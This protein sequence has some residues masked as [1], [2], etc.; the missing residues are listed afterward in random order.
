MFIRTT[1]GEQAHHQCKEVIADI[2]PAIFIFYYLFVNFYIYIYRKL[3]NY[4]LS[5]TTKCY[6]DQNKDSIQWI[7]STWIYYVEELFQINMIWWVANSKCL[8]LRILNL[9]G[10]KIIS[11]LN[12]LSL[13][14]NKIFWKKYICKT[15]LSIKHYPK[16]H[17][18]A[19]CF[20]LLKLKIL[21]E[22]MYMPFYG[23]HSCC[24]F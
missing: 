24:Q 4:F 12:N 11:H 3:L 23:C 5:H 15:V 2:S 6:K 13:N 20:S 8:A 10:Y 16:Y 17:H 21:E 22:D 7:L 14:K 1:I 9:R 18:L 19:L